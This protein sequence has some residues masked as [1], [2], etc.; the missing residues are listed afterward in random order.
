[1]ERIVVTGLGVV[2]SIGCTI[3]DFEKGLIEGKSGC[4]P[5]VNFDASGFEEVHACEVKDFEPL[6]YIRNNNIEELG[7]SS[8]FAIAAARMALADAG[9]D[10]V[11]LRGQ[12][13]PVII[14]TTDGESQPLDDLARH[15]VAEGLESVPSE[16]IEKTAAGNLANAVSREFGLRGPSRTI[17]TACSAGNYAIGNAFDMLSNGVAQIAIC[18]GSDSVCRKTYSGF[19]RLGTIAPVQCQPFDLNRKGILTGEGSGVLVLETLSSA[20]ARGASIHAEVLGYGLSCDA[21]HMVSPNAESVARCIRIAHSNARV[22]ATDVDYVCAHGTGTSA[23]DTV[24]SAAIKAVFGT[25]IPPVSSI[26]SMV[27]HSMGAASAIASI[28]CIL[29]I[30]RG[31]LPPTINHQTIDPDCIPDCVSNHSRKLTV[32]I[33][34]NNG[35]AFGGN[36]AITIFSSIDREVA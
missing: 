10:D 8:Q 36:N 30:G 20:Q 13:V 1:M 21:D 29:A 6:D 15:W 9:L 32:H 18:G 4:A 14:G 28:A 11:A 24:E 27:G 7:R 33:A 23:N 19:S 35:F 26:K 16:L 34:Q 22:S 3:A 12:R 5:A 2:S 17:S 25:Q 31:F